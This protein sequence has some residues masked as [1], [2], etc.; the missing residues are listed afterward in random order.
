MPPSWIL[1]SEPSTYSWAA[2]VADGRTVWDGV[3][4]NAALLHLRAM[5]KGDE[6]LLYHSGEERAIIGIAQIARGPYPDPG[7]DDPK[8]VVVDLV[9]VRPL[10]RSVTL[11]EIKAV[12]GLAD[13]GL[14]RISR[15]SCMP[16]SPAH[17]ALLRGLGVK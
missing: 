10:K 2:L 13:L 16:V 5:R 3:A 11:G 14:V 8:R 9:P 1:K 12:P 4:S 7:L 17:R 6:V 15:L